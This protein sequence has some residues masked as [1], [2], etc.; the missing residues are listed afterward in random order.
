MRSLKTLPDF[1]EKH[2]FREDTQ[3][4]R[5]TVIFSAFVCSFKDKLEFHRVTEEK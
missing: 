5:H 1:A 3:V 2:H 4:R